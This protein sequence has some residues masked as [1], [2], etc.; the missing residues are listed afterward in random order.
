MERYLV[1]FSSHP[2]PPSDATAVEILAESRISA[3][4]R[5]RREVEIPHPWTFARAIPWPPGCPDV[6]VALARLA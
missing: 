4:A 1:I 6:D 2:E 3:I 5:A